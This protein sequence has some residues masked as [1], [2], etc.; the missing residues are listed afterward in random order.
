MSRD[1]RGGK[2]RGDGGSDK[3]KPSGRQKA[4]DAYGSGQKNFR[5][6]EEIQAEEEEMRRKMKRGGDEE[7]EEEE[8][9]EEG[10]GDDDDEEEEGGEGGDDDDEE[11]SGEEG[12]NKK[13]ANANQT[14]TKKGKPATASA[15]KFVKASNLD[16]NKAAADQASGKGLNRKERE[17]MEKEAARK[18]YLDAYA[19]GATPEAKSDLARLR[20][21]RREREAAQKR[22]EEEKK[23]KEEKKATQKVRDT[24]RRK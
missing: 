3:V 12:D 9:E 15:G 17:A 22:N 18:K 13:T 11:G 21:I 1:R 14:R 6:E 4:R 20:Q 5:S 8:E 16:V 24:G 7:E 19:A 23:A 10:S 2:D